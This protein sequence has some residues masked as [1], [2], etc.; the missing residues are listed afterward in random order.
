VYLQADTPMPH[1]AIGH[2]ETVRYAHGH[3]HDHAA[4]MMILHDVEGENWRDLYWYWMIMYQQEL[5]P[6]RTL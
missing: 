6:R 5:K 3:E 1:L 4:L 2:R